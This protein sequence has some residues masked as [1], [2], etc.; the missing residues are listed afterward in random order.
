[1]DG[2]TWR[3]VKWIE[4]DWNCGFW[5]L[6]N[7]TVSQSLFLLFVK[8]HILIWSSVFLKSYTSNFA[9]SIADKDASL[10]FCLVPVRCLPRPS[11]CLSVTYPR[12][13]TTWSETH[14]PHTIMRPRD[15]ANW[16]YWQNEPDNRDTAPL[17]FQCTS[18]LLNPRLQCF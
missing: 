6:F 12:P 9:S 1:M 3:R 5:K 10:G 16:D 2:Q 4:M 18:S 8:F 7:L 14:G 11:R 17:K 15:Y 13:W